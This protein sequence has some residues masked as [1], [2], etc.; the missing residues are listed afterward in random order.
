MLIQPFI[1]MF[2]SE[3]FKS[4]ILY[5]IAM[6]LFLLVV[7]AVLVGITVTTSI[8]TTFLTNNFVIIILAIAAL[9]F[10]CLLPFWF[11]QGY[12]WELTYRIIQRES[13]V[14]ASNI[15]NGKVSQVFKITLPERNVFKFIWRGF[16]SFVATIIM[17][18]PYVLIVYAYLSTYGINGQNEFFSNPMTPILALALIMNILTPALLWNYANRNSVLA[19]LN[20]RKAV[21]IAGNYTGRYILNVLLMIVYNF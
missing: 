3:G 6:T 21:Y 5:L 13:D 14:K 20:I 19:V 16:A 18:T 4:H 10:F 9:L 12:F 1:W 17:Y 2:K 11:G 8:F 15:Y 7:S